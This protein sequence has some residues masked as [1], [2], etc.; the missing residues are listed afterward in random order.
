MR[1]AFQIFFEGEGYR[2]WLVLA[3]LILASIL[4]IIGIGALLP[5][6]SSTIDGDQPWLAKFALGVVSALGINPD[7]RGFFTLLV[8][9]FATKYILTYL[10][11]NISSFAEIEVSARLRTRLLK[12]LFEANWRFLVHR[13][14]GKLT[15]EIVNNANRAADAYRQ[16]A[17]FFNYAI[18]AVFYLCAAVLVSLE[19]T[20]IGFLVGLGFYFSF[21]ALMKRSRELGAR[22]TKTLSIL[23]TQLS[24]TLS[25][26]KPIVAM[27]RKKH[28]VER[29]LDEDRKVR[30]TGRR[31]A[32]LGNAIYTVSDAFLVGTLVIGLFIANV[33]LDVPFSELAIMAIVS[34]RAIET[35]KQSQRCLQAVASAEAAFWS[36]KVQMKDLETMQEERKGKATPKLEH[37]CGFEAVS[38][39]HDAKTVVENVSITIPANQITVLIGPSGAGKT[40]LVDLLLG[41]YQPSTGKITLDDVPLSEIDLG[42][43]RKMIGYVPQETTLLH[44]TLRENITLGDPGILD[45][46][47]FDA[48][49]LAGAARFVESLPDRLDTITGELG[50]RFSGGE[51]QRL[52]LARALVI[53]PKILLLD[54]VTSALDPE[55][56]IEI[57]R[58]IKRLSGMLTV[59]AVTHRPAWTT[60]ANRI[61]R[62][63]NGFVEHVP[64]PGFLPTDPD[65]VASP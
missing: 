18:Q 45:A 64:S 35:L 1:S 39:R 17:R 56:E 13:K 30:A 55:T 24:D 60:I 42:L 23:S 57:C 38:F 31:L 48:L 32:I 25:N 15:N 16:S 26:I 59:L 5:V 10:A 21:S 41:L 2:S 11:M 19:L 50:A 6:F 43:W 51:R 34:I 46:T 27:D 49:R 63:E 8:V 3:A 33:W 58:N 61:Y 28:T 36:A 12:L 29:I 65:S 4:E 9:V 20:L 52:A 53:Q 37:G 14:A 22:R 40:T 7:G 54:E 44:G 47:I 62:V